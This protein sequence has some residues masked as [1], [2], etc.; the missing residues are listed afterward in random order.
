MSYMSSTSNIN[1]NKNTQRIMFKNLA[2]QN[3]KNTERYHTN[4]TLS[5]PQQFI[6]ASKARSKLIQAAEDSKYKEFDLRVLVGHANFLDKIMDN[7]DRFRESQSIETSQSLIDQE[8]DSDE[9]DIDSDED[10]DINQYM[11]NNRFQHVEQIEDL[12]KSNALHHHHH[13]YHTDEEDIIINSSFECEASLNSKSIIND[14]EEEGDSFNA[15]HKFHS[16]SDDESEYFPSTSDSYPE[17]STINTENTF[18]LSDSKVT[19]SGEESSPSD[20]DSDFDDEDFITPYQS[21]NSPYNSDSNSSSS[22]SDIDSFTKHHS[23]SSSSNNSSEE[24]TS[25]NALGYTTHLKD[26]TKITRQSNNSS[27]ENYISYIPNPSEIIIEQDAIPKDKIDEINSITSEDDDDDD[28]LDKH[29]GDKFTTI[30]E[31]PEEEE[32]MNIAEQDLSGVSV[33]NLSHHR[34]SRHHSHIR[35]KS[36]NSTQ[37]EDHKINDKNFDVYNCIFPTLQDPIKNNQCYYKRRLTNDFMNIKT[38]EFF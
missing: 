27:N 28:L 2:S 32:T 19:S 29:L 6:L 21:S 14:Y 18:D 25:I 36:R 37:R 7:I 13:P 31:Y 4:D 16:T 17:F 3:N 22:D 20:S 8:E 9:E 11:G 23:S 12:H 33:R 26:S 15:I 34:N 5:M 1:P 24:D 10:Y 30:W 35:T 38:V